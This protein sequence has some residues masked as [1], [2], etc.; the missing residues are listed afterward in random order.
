[1]TAQLTTVDPKQYGLEESKATQ[2]RAGLTPIIEERMILAEQYQR[3]ITQELNDATLKEARE[4]RLKIRDNRTKGIETWH[5]AN[6][7]FYLRGG[8]FVDAIK[9]V[10]VLENE[11]MEDNL[12]SIEKHFENIEKEKQEVLHNERIALITPYVDDTIG[13]D[14]RTMQDDVFEAFLS[15]KKSAY[16]ARIEAERLAEEQRIESARIE[17][18]RIEAQRIEN[19]RLKKE[20]EEKE[21]QLKAEREAAAEA[22]RLA[23]IEADKAIAEQQRLAKIEA[24]KQAAILEAQRKE[25]SRIAAELK[26]KQDKEDSERKEREAQELE[27]KKEAEKLAKLGDK[28]QLKAWIDTFKIELP[29]SEL[30][31]HDKALLIKQKFDAFKKWALSE[32]ETI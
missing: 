9:K 6:K 13:L 21:E 26:A 1:M 24:D 20:A 32:I 14:F 15:A 25:T 29:A 2:M 5:K 8:Q 19:A 10:E 27:A 23:K 31:N 11:R 16:E 12:L 28:A 30:L 18:E 17:A 7:D 22:Q 3:V 4:L